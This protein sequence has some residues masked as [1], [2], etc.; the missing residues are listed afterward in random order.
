MNVIIFATNIIF[1]LEIKMDVEIKNLK[2]I[3]S[4]LLQLAK[5]IDVLLLHIDKIFY[6]EY[7]RK[8]CIL[9]NMKNL[10]DKKFFSFEKLK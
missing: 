9:R 4:S 10:A 6:N 3:H 7:Y 1:I 5:E 8:L 2:E